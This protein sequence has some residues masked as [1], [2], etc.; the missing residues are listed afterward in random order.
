M[1]LL[2]DNYDSFTYNLY[3]EIGKLTKQTIKVVKNDQV[4]VEDLD[5]PTLMGLILSPGPGR[6]NQA[7]NLNAVLAAA[8]GRVPVLGV[9]LG[10]Q[11]IGEVYGAK[12]V[13]APLMH[14][15]TS[16]IHQQGKQLSGILAGCPTTFTVGRYHSLMIDPATIPNHLTVTAQAD[17]GTVQAVADEEN[18]VYGVE[19]HPESI[20]TDQA[21]AKQIFTNFLAYTGESNHD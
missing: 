4:R 7:G 9:C 14:G 21:A 20:M 16:L 3:Q 17:D 5:E 13:T 8:I 12:I 11:A 19:F 1:L 18:Y 6:P 2:I 10:H 15:K